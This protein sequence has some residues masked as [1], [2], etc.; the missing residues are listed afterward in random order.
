MAATHIAAATMTALQPQCRAMM[1]I[2]HES[3][4]VTWKLANSGFFFVRND[5]YHER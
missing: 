2:Y 5:M 4:N 1:Q 3:N